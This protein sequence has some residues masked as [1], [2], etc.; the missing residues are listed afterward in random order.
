MQNFVIITT[1]KQRGTTTKQKTQGFTI[2][3]KG[4]IV[5]QGAKQ[6]NSINQWDL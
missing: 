6:N 4:I 3:V 1:H 2:G 5:L